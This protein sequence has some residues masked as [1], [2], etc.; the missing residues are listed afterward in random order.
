MSFGT[1]SNARSRKYVYL[2]N[3]M[4][5]AVNHDRLLLQNPR[6][7]TKNIKIK[8][9]PYRKK[10]CLLI[11]HYLAEWT[12][13]STWVRRTSILL[14]YRFSSVLWCL[15]INW[16]VNN[17]AARGNKLQLQ[18]GTTAEN[19]LEHCEEICLNSRISRISRET[20]VAR[21]TWWNNVI[22]RSATRCAA[23][24]VIH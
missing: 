13:T 20:K 8:N 6:K 24:V 21:L 1:S 18:R 9:R 3:T 7:I 11:E 23:C 2:C 22:T 15:N 14:F 4:I 17:I 5:A 19:F 12:S 16:T 10:I